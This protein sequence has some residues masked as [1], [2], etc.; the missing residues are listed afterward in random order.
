[1]AVVILPFDILKI[2]E[3]MDIC[4]SHVIAVD[5]STYSSIDPRVYIE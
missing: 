4:R 3:V 5:N 1:M 2:I